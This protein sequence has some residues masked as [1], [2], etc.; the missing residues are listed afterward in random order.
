LL[1]QID[2]ISKGETKLL[3]SKLF[4]SASNYIKIRIMTRFAKQHGENEK[5]KLFHFN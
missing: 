1:T 2:D 3:H 5:R 4:L